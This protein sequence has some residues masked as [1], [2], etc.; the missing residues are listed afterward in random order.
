ML[1][2][3]DI[4]QRVK[5]LLAQWSCPEL[6]VL[7]LLTLSLSYDG[8]IYSRDCLAIFPENYAW[9][10]L[11]INYEGGLVRRGLLGTILAPFA[12]QQHFALVYTIINAVL[13]IVCYA[14]FIRALA[15]IFE[16][17]WLLVLVGS[18]GLFA[19]MP[20]QNFIRKDIFIKAA[21]FL[22][23]CLAARAA[24]KKASVSQTLCLFTIIYVPV[25]LVHELILFYV[26]LPLA[27]L[28]SSS[29]VDRER[30][31]VLIY[32]AAL[33]ISSVL[34]AVVFSGTI[35]Q[36][37]AIA[38]FWLHFYPQ[39]AEQ[40]SIQAINFIGQGLLDRNE[41]QYLLPYLL[42]PDLRNSIIKAF[43][44]TFGPL[45]FVLFRY[46]L[47]YALKRLFGRPGVIVVCVTSI[48][49]FLRNH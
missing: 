2:S 44:L 28:F 31:M 41:H 10:D 42:K 22:L 27:L 33:T 30:R 4:S 7:A 36:R 40:N 25:F 3:S 5:N 14:F 39:M 47:L 17:F 13:V 19:F 12:G 16:K 38:S 23:F 29:S 26:F 46:R 43:L 32:G 9:G 37:Q 18:P 45:T 15:V 35:P 48:F 49:S 6:V 8:W 11:F 1:T 24:V 20:L 21:Y 34:F